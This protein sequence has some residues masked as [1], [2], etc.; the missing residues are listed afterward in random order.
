M[1][2]LADRLD[3]R[4]GS[5]DEPHDLAVLELGMVAHQPEDGVRTVLAARYRRVARAL[6][7]LGLGQAHLG[8]EQLETIVRISD[9][10]LDLLAAE[11][12]SEHGIKALDALRG[13]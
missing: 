11:L 10:F 1:G 9:G 3:G 8:V 5:A 7:L 6:L 13:V 4:L 2:A 12:T